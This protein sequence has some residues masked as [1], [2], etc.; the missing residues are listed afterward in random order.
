MTGRVVRLSAAVWS[1]LLA[2]TFLLPG[3]VGASV[4]VDP[5]FGASTSTCYYT[6]S[7]GTKSTSYHNDTGSVYV[8]TNSG[9]CGWPSWEWSHPVSPPS[10]Y[11][12]LYKFDSSFPSGWQSAASAAVNTWDVQQYY[13]PVMNLTTGSTYDILFRYS[14]SSACSGVVWYACAEVHWG[15]VSSVDNAE[16]YQYWHVTL[17]TAYSWGVRTAGKFDV[18][19]LLTNELGHVWYLDHNPNWASGV[20]QLQACVFGQ[21]W[22]YD[23]SGHYVTCTNAPGYCGDRTQ[24]LA[25]DQ[26]TLGHIYGAIGSPIPYAPVQKAGGSVDTPPV[27]NAQRQDVLVIAIPN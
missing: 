19:S 14:S 23:T 3:S 26:S 16:K 2:A 8:D 5:H 21:T 22:C 11:T 1:C 10:W 27:P 13:S 25:G 18:Q 17:N 4:T 12:G 24:V 6:Y 20:V 9:D 7:N 15:S